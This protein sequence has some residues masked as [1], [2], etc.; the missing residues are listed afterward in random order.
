M[1]ATDPSFLITC[2]QLSVITSK[3]PLF[4]TSFA[5]YGLSIW[6]FQLF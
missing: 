1:H 5:L 6:F 4:K 2:T 3:L